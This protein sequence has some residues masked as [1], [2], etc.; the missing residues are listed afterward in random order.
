M[1]DISESN[2][3]IFYTVTHFKIAIFIKFFRIPPRS[4][5]YRS[6]RFHNFFLIDFWREKESPILIFAKL[7]GN[8]L[9]SWLICNCQ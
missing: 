6:G 9:P 8:L 4:I 3:K 1:N 2:F 5:L 7:S